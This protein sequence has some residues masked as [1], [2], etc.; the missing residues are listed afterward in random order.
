MA[1]PSSPAPR[2]IMVEGSGTGLEVSFP[3]ISALALESSRTLNW[4]TVV[5]K[6]WGMNATKIQLVSPSQG[7]V[8]YLFAA[9][10]L[11]S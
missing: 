1:N 4:V 11:I 5:M 9:F 3:K 8:L 10:S 7:Y 2:S 6:A